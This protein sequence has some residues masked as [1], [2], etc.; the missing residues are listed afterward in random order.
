MAAVRDELCETCGVTEAVRLTVRG[1]RER[2]DLDVVALVTRL[3]LGEPKA[4]DLWVAK[5]RTRHHPVVTELQSLCTRNGFGCDDSLS[6]GYVRELQLSS[7]IADGV[8]VR[9]VGAHARIDR[10]RLGPF[11]KFNARVFKAVACEPRCETD[12]K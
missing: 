11:L 4:R 10:D 9:N 8:D 2:R 5:C 12:G 3:L 6:L 1:E 7:D